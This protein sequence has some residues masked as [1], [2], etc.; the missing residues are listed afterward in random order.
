MKERYNVAPW[1]DGKDAVCKA[2]DGKYIL[3]TDHLAEIR[4]IVDTYDLLIDQCDKKNSEL[5][6]ERDGYRNGQQ[7]VQALLAKQIDNSLKLAAENKRLVALMV[8]N[9]RSVIESDEKL[10]EELTE[11]LKATEEEMLFWRRESRL[12]DAGLNMAE[13]RIKELAAENKRLREAL[14][15]LARLGNEP[16]LG[17]SVGNIIAQEALKEASHESK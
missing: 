12:S 3:Y 5:E 4:E 14:E 17:N 1:N 11:K 8:D 15:K 16:M 7:Q 9:L 2:E 10:V 13:D 6:D